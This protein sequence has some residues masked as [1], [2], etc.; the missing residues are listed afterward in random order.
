MPMNCMKLFFQYVF[1]AAAA[2]GLLCSCGKIAADRM[3]VQGETGE[4]A[5]NLEIL[6]EFMTSG[7]KAGELTEPDEIIIKD[8]W[9]LEYKGDPTK[10]STPL[11]SAK[12]YEVDSDDGSGSLS[13][14]V[15][16]H[17]P[18]GKDINSTMTYIVIA[19]T[20][21]SRLD[22]KG[23]AETL[24]DL[25]TYGKPVTSPN[26]LYQT[27]EDGKSDLVLSGYRSYV[28]SEIEEGISIS[29]CR[30]VAKLS[31]NITC[32]CEDLRIEAIRLCQIPNISIWADQ[33]PMV[34][35]SS[36][37]PDTKIIDF[38]V[39]ELENYTTG[40][41]IS[42]NWYL[43]RNL[44][45]KITM[46]DK[47]TYKYVSMRQPTCVKIYASDAS[48]IDEDVW[49]H[50]RN[51][52]IYSF[53][54][55][56][57]EGDDWKYDV[58]PNHI[59]T[60]NIEINDKGNMDADYTRV[61]HIKY[62]VLEKSNSYILPSNGNGHTV[63]AIPLSIMG[64]YWGEDQVAEFNKAN[65]LT[66]ESIWKD[67]TKNQT[68]IDGIWWTY[69][70][71]IFLEGTYGNLQLIG[72]KARIKIGTINK[73]PYIYVRPKG[74][75]QFYGRNC[76]LV[77][78]VKNNIKQSDANYIWSWHLWLTDYNPD[79][80]DA[81]TKGD[82][83]IKDGYYVMSR[84]LGDISD[85]RSNGLYYQYG[86]KDPFIGNGYVPESPTYTVANNM[87]IG[88]G[89]VSLDNAVQYP[90]TFYTGTDDWMAS[91]SYS[92][93]AWNNGGKYLDAEIEKSLFDPCP[94]GWKVAPASL[95]SDFGDVQTNFNGGYTD[96]YSIPYPASGLRGENDGT[97]GGF[98]TDVNLW[99]A[100]PYSG[101]S[102]NSSAVT[103]YNNS[104]TVSRAQGRNVR[105]VKK[106]ETA[107][108]RS[109]SHLS[110]S[111]AV[112]ANHTPDR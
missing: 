46:A 81:L 30:N 73:E 102:I 70:N 92:G 96:E 79:A 82:I 84:N 103:Y 108:V 50:D 35:I 61:E 56:H 68:N 13:R 40:S 95:F 27:T 99:A 16:V 77:L 21:D 111:S 24:Q 37:F 93:T 89:P 48:N 55:K 90:Y 97:I 41:T 8:F 62:V 19:N 33:S 45:D 74:E 11:V 80:P 22:F 29:L 49:N 52:Y 32:N 36:K 14:L 69:R 63:Y 109:E 26:D 100:E 15:Q 87:K 4:L 44:R 72:G 57:Q 2:F 42:F 94:P 25:A 18:T 71:G 83:Y 39:E 10:Q 12:Y 47:Y 91:N 59:Y 28:A 110:E 75:L 85:D 43:P 86:R 5:L 54:V 60:M 76:N 6:S 107:A 64:D 7:S 38:E 23:E 58:H 78:G 104:N 101:V 3:S 31:V 1:A 88:T 9:L 17:L 20:H 106:I 53:Y 112:Y 66:F 34:A 98:G 105:C 65:N 67:K 51:E